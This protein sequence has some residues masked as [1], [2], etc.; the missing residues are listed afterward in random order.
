MFAWFS[1]FFSSQA[2]LREVGLIMFDGTIKI[3]EASQAQCGWMARWHN[4][5]DQWSILHDDGT[6]TGT[7]LV[8][9]WVKVSGWPMEYCNTVAPVTKPPSFELMHNVSA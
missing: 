2:E 6:V 7:S 1:R 4:A 5:A 8:K 9:A 3:V